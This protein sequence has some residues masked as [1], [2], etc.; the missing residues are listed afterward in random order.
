M[1]GVIKEIKRKNKKQTKGAVINGMYFDRDVQN[2][3]ISYNNEP[4]H[5]KRSIIFKDRIAYALDKLAENLIHTNKFYY[6]VN[7]DIIS[8]KHEVVNFLLERLHKYDET[9]G[10]AFS[11]FDRI[12]LNYL[13]GQNKDKYKQLIANR[14]TDL[15]SDADE[16]FRRKVDVTNG[17]S[18]LY[19]FTEIFISYVDKNAHRLFESKDRLIVEHILMLFKQRDTCEIFNKKIFYHIIKTETSCSTLQVTRILKLVENLF[20]RMYAEFKETDYISMNQLYRT[21]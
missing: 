3:I 6:F 14:M 15:S 11:Y 21:K 10:K 1:F 8:A 18:H 5:I 7:N 13:I 17:Q 12:A 16:A 2:A 19:N 4:D 9:K 20:Y